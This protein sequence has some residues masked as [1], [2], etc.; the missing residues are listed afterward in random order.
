MK[1]III[2]IL[3]FLFTCNF[4]QA[5]SAFSAERLAESVH[6]YIQSQQDDRFDVQIVTNINAQNFNQ[7]GVKA[8]FSGAEYLRNGLNTIKVEFF[9]T[10]GTLSTLNIHVRANDKHAEQEKAQSSEIVIRRG[11]NVRIVV[12]SG[13]VQVSAAGTALQD[14][15][16]GDL[17]RVRRNGTRSKILQGTAGAD[18]NI[19]ISSNKLSSQ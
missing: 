13:S 18:G 4:L 12:V 7:S 11:E 19:Y 10:A 14:A 9:T 16:E 5:N 6:S 17:I 2:N 8:R 1:Y 3:L 15:A